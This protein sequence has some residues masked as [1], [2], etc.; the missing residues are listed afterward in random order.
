MKWFSERMTAVE[1]EVPDRYARRV[2]EVL[3]NDGLLQL[4]DISYLNTSK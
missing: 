2:T 1:I 4:E 3:A